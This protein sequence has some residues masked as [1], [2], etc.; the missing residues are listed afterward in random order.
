MSDHEIDRCEGASIIPKPRIS[1]G[2]IDEVVTAH[3]GS[4][5]VRGNAQPAVFYRQ[6]AMYLAKRVGGWPGSAIGRFYNG[7]DHSTVCHAV[8]KIESLR[9]A[10]PEIE[11]LLEYL[12]DV[13]KLAESPRP[14][15]MG[16]YAFGSGGRGAEVALSEEIVEAITER[17]L[18]RLRSET[19]DA[20]G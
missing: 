7:R 2:H 19:G 17:V 4:A 15:S 3:L 12:T 10:R 9:M 6:I 14:A 16:L 20:S 11:E 18:K 8:Q 1:L 5:R 13:L